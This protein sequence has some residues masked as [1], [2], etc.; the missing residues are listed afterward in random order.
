M[1][2]RLVVAAALFYNV[3]AQ[4]VS[5]S[6]A[7]ECGYRKLALEN[8]ATL[9]PWLTA[10]QHLAVFEALE[11]GTLCG[12]TPPDHRPAAPRPAVAAPSPALS[13]FVD[14]AAGSDGAAGEEA[15]PVATVQAALALL[16]KNRASGGAKNTIV[17]KDGVH[18]LKETMTLGPDDSGTTITAAPGADAWLS[19]GQPLGKLSWAK[20][21]HPSGGVVWVASLKGTGLT[22]VPGAAAAASCHQ[23]ADQSVS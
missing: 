21:E 2:A 8:A 5:G 13:I 3:S 9:Q 14:A 18:F 7:L 16:R 19:G 6:I 11:L 15:A 17:L 20:A 23:R 4:G 12:E 1:A 22:K 10:A